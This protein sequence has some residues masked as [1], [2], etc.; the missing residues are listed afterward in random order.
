MNFDNKEN[1]MFHQTRNKIPFLAL[2]VPTLV[3]V[4]GGQARADCD[5]M[6]TL[7]VDQIGQETN[8]W[9]WAAGTQMV[10]KFKG[11][12]VTQCQQADA[13]FAHQDCCNKPVPAGC[14]QPGWPDFP[15]WGF[16]TAMTDWEMA[17]SWAQLKSQID[18]DQ[19][20][21]FAWGW[22]GGGGHLMV[23][24]GYCE[25]LNPGRDIDKY[26][27]INDPLP[28]G[29][30]GNKYITYAEFL[31]VPGNHIHWRDYYNTKRP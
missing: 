28:V 9:C 16:Q 11:V 14:I 29:T 10:T 19:P 31:A 23:A 21:A 3:A 5:L 18:L 4:L 13:L 30:G 24:R 7:P 22:D 2:V 8:Q 17:L 25:F 1:I 26:V 15:H 20:V 12:A 27:L 6:R